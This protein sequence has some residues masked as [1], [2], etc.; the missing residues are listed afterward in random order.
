MLFIAVTPTNKR[1]K[2]WDKTQGVN[3]AIAEICSDQPNT[4]WIATVGSFL[5]KDGKP[6]ANYFIDDQL[7][8]NESGYDVWGELIMA[9]LATVIG[10][11]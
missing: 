4:H 1:W 8:L 5:G 10:A 2:V 6:L 7:H 11:P 9:R 3:A